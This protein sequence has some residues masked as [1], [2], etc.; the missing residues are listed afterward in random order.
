M[1]LINPSDLKGTYLRSIKSTSTNEDD[2]ITALI[3]ASLSCVAQF[4]GY[5]PASVTGGATLDSATYTYRFD[6][7]G[8][9]TV[10]LPFA[11]ITAV[12]SVEDDP[13]CVFDGS[14]ALSSGDYEITPGTLDGID[15]LPR[16]SHGSWSAGSKAGKIVCTAGYTSLPPAL[17]HGVC[18]LVKHSFELMDRQGQQSGNS[19]GISFSWRPE[20]IPAH[21]QQILSPFVLVISFT[22]GV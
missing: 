11:P 7:H 6:T 17:K 18:L 12:S 5:T 20:D 22:G 8:G 13:D 2:W 3:A 14:L 16:G 4:L 21:I 9:R 10:R 19:N 15:L 1:P